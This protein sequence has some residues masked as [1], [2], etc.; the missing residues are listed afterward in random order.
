MAKTKVT[1]NKEI[2]SNREELVEKI[3]ELG[4]QERLKVKIENQMNEAITKLK[5]RYEEEAEPCNN[6]IKAITAGIEAYSVVHRD[7]LTDG[8]KTKT[9]N[10]P[11]GTLSWRKSP[12]SVRLS[13]KEKVIELLKKKGLSRFIRTKEEISKELI[14]SEPAAVAGVKGIT[15]VK[16]KEVLSIEPFEVKLDAV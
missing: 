13:K 11:S 4:R 10:L 6:K 12:P 2:P 5:R 15:I 8:G 3:E 9:V 16:E 1:I 7:E 14:L